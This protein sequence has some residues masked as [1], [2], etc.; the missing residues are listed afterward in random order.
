MENL[1]D[2]SDNGIVSDDTK[3]YKPTFWFKD[4]IHYLYR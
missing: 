4:D 3:D 1:P 2:K